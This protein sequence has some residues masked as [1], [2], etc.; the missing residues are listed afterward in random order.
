MQ[1]LG[2]C[3]LVT[4]SASLATAALVTTD[5]AAAPS[6][7]ERMEFLSLLIL[8]YSLLTLPLTGQ[9]PVWRKPAHGY[10]LPLPTTQ[11][12]EGQGVVGAHRQMADTLGN[13]NTVAAAVN[14]S[15]PLPES[16]AGIEEPLLPQPWAAGPWC[17][18]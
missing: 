14:S 11:S 8:T 15:T 12:T 13:Q 5:A 16:N 17:S 4:I 6:D 7:A 9:A 1:E 2:A 18:S 10:R 3:T